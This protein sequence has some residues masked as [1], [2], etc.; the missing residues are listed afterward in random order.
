VLQF[1]EYHGF[2]V[3]LE[4]ALAATSEPESKDVPSGAQRTIEV[5]MAFKAAAD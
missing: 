2:I 1:L 3:C 4:D 5:V